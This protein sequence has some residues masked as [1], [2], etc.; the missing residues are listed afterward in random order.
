MCCLAPGIPVAAVP[1]IILA[2]AS[3]LRGQGILRYEIHLCEETRQVFGLQLRDP[4]V[5]P[6]AEPPVIG[7]WRAHMADVLEMEGDVPRRAALE[8]VFLLTETLPA[9]TD[10]NDIENA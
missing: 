7:R 5:P 4:G 2:R 9:T 1:I 8:R 6:A 3:A 10:D